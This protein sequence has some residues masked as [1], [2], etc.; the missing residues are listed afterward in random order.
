MQVWNDRWNTGRKRSP[1]RHYRTSLSGY[2]FATKV[3]I[4]NRKKLLNSNTSSTCPDN[5]VNFG[6][7]A[8]EGRRLGSLGHP[9]KF[10]LV[11][12]LGSVTALW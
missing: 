5:M 4:D 12:R 11:S 8:A 2:I 3:R 7:L 6:P 9:C 10:Q 1:S